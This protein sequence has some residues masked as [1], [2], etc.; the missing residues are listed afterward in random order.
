M[1]RGKKEIAIRLSLLG[2]VFVFGFALV[3]LYQN[4]IS[5]ANT[6]SSLIIKKKT[7]DNEQGDFVFNIKVSAP[8]QAYAYIDESDGTMVFFRDEPG[9]YQEKEVIGMRTYYTTIETYT[10]PDVTIG[11]FVPWQGQKS[12]VKKVIIQDEIKPKSMAYW[13]GNCVSLRKV[14]GLEKIDTSEVEG[15]HRL[16]YNCLSLD[17]ATLDMTHWDTSNVTNMYE[18]FMNTGQDYP[19]L[20]DETVMPYN[21]SVISV[22]LSSFDTTKV[23]NYDMMFYNFHCDTIYISDKWDLYKKDVFR[24]YDKDTTTKEYAQYGVIEDIKG[25]TLTLTRSDQLIGSESHSTPSLTEAVWVKKTYSREGVENGSITIKMEGVPPSSS[26]EPERMRALMAATR[27]AVIKNELW[28][29]LPYR[30]L[31][32][33]DFYYSDYKLYN[34][35]SSKKIVWEDGVELGHFSGSS[36]RNRPYQILINVPALGAGE[37]VTVPVQF[38]RT[39]VLFNK[40]RSNFSDQEFPTAPITYFS[41]GNTDRDLDLSKYGGVDNGDGSY[42]FT[43]KS[44]EELN[45][46]DMLDGYTYEVWE[47][48]TKGWKLASIDGDTQ[49]TK[50][51]GTMGGK[52]VEHVFLNQKLTEELIAAQPGVVVSPQTGDKNV[53][54]LMSMA[55]SAVILLGAIV[56]RARRS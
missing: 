26:S 49:K 40:S 48:D 55:G 3:N 35:E 45:I 43:I 4:N 27:I 23:V 12:L 53:L 2:V 33:S 6:A 19:T 37:T 34:E 31:Y 8:T 24:F 5:A 30:S 41:I 1:L 21:A 42:K 9:K 32:D 13:F 28:A 52:D 51:Q 47:A 54:A 46:P 38:K 29:D 17:V 7:V 50:I 22:D 16:F 56:A 18:M 36:T 20:F 10:T 44:G 14:E 15:M 25:V 11:Q 39:G